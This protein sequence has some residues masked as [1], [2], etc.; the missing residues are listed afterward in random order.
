MLTRFSGLLIVVNVLR[1]PDV[2]GVDRPGQQSL[3]FVS[4]VSLQAL[5]DWSHSNLPRVF[6]TGRFQFGRRRRDNDQITYK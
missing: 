4:G 3:Q 1:E 6:Y 5:Q 2:V